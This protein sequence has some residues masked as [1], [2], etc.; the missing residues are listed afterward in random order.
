MAPTSPRIRV[1]R[2]VLADLAAAQAVERE[3]FDEGWSPTAFES[4]LR[5]NGAA[6]YVLLERAAAHRWEALGFA[7]LWLQYDEAHVVT[8]AVLPHERRNGYGRVLVHALV[9][10]AAAYSMADATLEVRAS[11]TAARA[12]YS[13]YGFWEVGE[14]KQYYRDPPEDGVIMTTEALASERYR[15]RIARLG[16][17]LRERFGDAAT[18][19]AVGMGFDV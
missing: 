17:S 5:H 7:G 6:R 12:L 3:S 14:R 18:P 4:E 16:T 2:L 8:V 13:G 9:T 19:S 15:G 10:V 1:R 11:N